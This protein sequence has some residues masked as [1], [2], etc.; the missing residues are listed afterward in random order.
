MDGASGLLQ[1]TGEDQRLV[2]QRAG[3]FTLYLVKAILQTGTYSADHPLAKAATS[4]MYTMF[5]DLT[6]QASE[7]TYVLLSAV[8][9][10]GVML[11]GLLAEP[12]EV[13]KTFRGVMGDHFVAKF[14][15]YFLRN[16]IAAFTI[17]R[18][19]EKPEFDAF[20][21]I[22][23]RY[24]SRSVAGAAA[25]SELVSA[26]S[27][28]LTRQGILHVTVVGMDEMVGA[29]R[30][31][32]WAVK[33]ALS[34]L[35]KDIARL[36]MLKDVASDVVRQ[37]KVQAIQDIVR[38]ITKI[39]LLR[40]LLLNADLVS[41]GMT[42]AADLEIEDILL[43]AI[44]PRQ[45]IE[46]TRQ[47]MDIVAELAKPVPRLN[48]AG[49]DPRSITDAARRVTRKALQRIGATDLPEVGPM[50]QTAYEAELIPF[51]EMPAFVQR[52]VRAGQTT[53]RFLQHEDAYL[54]DFDACADP[55]SYLK[56]LNVLLIV[57]P[58]L[59]A[60]KEMRVVAKVFE[61]LSRHR[62]DP[63]PPFLGRNRFLDETLAHLD[64]G[65]FQ[66]QL[67]TMAATTPKEDRE[68]LEKG[69]AMFGTGVV[70][71]LVRFLG[72]S[73]DVSARKAVCSILERVG[74]DAAPFLID[75]LRAHRHQWY[76]VR[77]LLDVL[78][79]IGDESAVPTIQ[80][81]FGH[82]HA[83]V[84]EACVMVVSKL[85]GHDAEKMLLPFLDD[86]DET[87]VR[88][89]VLVLAAV[90][91]TQ[92][93]YLDR[94]KEIL[95][96]RHRHEDEPQELLQ[97]AALRA[98]LEYEKIYLP[99]EPDFEAVLL[100]IVTPPKWQAMM[101]GRLGIRRKIDTVVQ[102]AVEA[103]GAIGRSRAQNALLALVE[104]TGEGLKPYMV[105][106]IARIHQRL[107]GGEKPS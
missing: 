35:R 106:S 84:R 97:V 15:E 85:L 22:W 31:L 66:D 50:L 37:L 103:L 17:K 81:Y 65:R 89:A 80:Q 13:G 105:A 54:K 51:E 91:C 76:T 1:T 39:D 38:P 69:V 72:A 14:H 78:E 96:V 33:I 47:L 9:D 24:S 79:T 93:E 68:A 94:L 48:M 45:A 82:P 11:D 21:D 101:P 56:Y 98:L 87:V 36:P 34:R 5:R 77:N 28:A 90:H 44:P 16:R 41:E 12:I 100:D 99:D 7:L 59:T 60:R 32:N 88:R 57:L 53:D 75:E 92:A 29:V 67:I 83:R 18:E 20:V 64:S 86:A 4:D 102:V 19:I 63:V 95:R 62:A 104:E 73:D 58:E 8:D 2:K 74:S 42:V 10:K 26:L 49:R 3:E 23:T 25:S 70:P 27:E 71:G 107:G 6:I 40:D 55:K 61:I 46:M 43:G 52:Q 30:H